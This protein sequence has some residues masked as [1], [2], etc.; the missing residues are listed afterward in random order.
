M[1]TG[2]QHGLEGTV[3]TEPWAFESG[4]IECDAHWCVRPRG[5]PALDRLIS[6]LQRPRRG[7]ARQPARAAGQEGSVLQHLMTACDPVAA[8]AG[9]TDWS[10]DAALRELAQRTRCVPDAVV[11][12]VTGRAPCDLVDLQAHEE[13]CRALGVGLV[14]SHPHPSSITVVRIEADRNLWLQKKGGSAWEP[15]PWCKGPVGEAAIRS[16]IRQKARELAALPETLMADLRKAAE[17]CG[18]PKPYPRTKKDLAALIA[19]R[20]G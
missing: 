18:L 16:V 6:G 7:R 5:T 19:L 1:A 13:V 17:L 4:A 20:A 15:A 8:V 12:R 3:T 11:A 9:G 10:P 2:M 14:L